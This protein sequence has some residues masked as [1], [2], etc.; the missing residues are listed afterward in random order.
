MAIGEAGIGNTTTA[1]AVAAVMLGENVQNV[2]GR[3][4]GLSDE[5]LNRKQSAIKKAIELNKPDASDP[6]DILAKVGG[7]DIA[8]MCGAFLA[9]AA[10][11]V[12]LVVD[13]VIFSVA[14]L[15]AVRMN[16][17]VL[18]YIIPSH[19]SREPASILLC[20]ALG[21]DPVIN[22]GFKLGEGTGAVAL[23][24]LLDMAVSVYENSA[25]FA[26]LEM[27]AYTKQC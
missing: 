1:A 17:T 8:A 20:S 23:F 10:Y 11:K 15:A 16:K 25:T 13:G 2:T 26:D 4:S 19:I 6:I 21:F 18:E 27:E 3:G 24:P 14:A 12:T 22:G 5:G 9:A 7:Y